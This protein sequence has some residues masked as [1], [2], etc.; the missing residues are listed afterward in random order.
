[1]NPVRKG[2]GDSGHVT[3]TNPRVA[4]HRLRTALATN[5][6]TEIPG[7][8]TLVARVMGIL[9]GIGRQLDS[10]VDVRQVM[11]RHA[12]AAE[13]GRLPGEFPGP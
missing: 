13:L 7:D 9:S 2:L 3:G 4:D 11:R 6:L 1:M 5:A 8:L 12:D 10:P